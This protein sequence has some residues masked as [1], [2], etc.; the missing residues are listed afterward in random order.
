MC[1]K[2]ERKL[3]AINIPKGTQDTYQRFD[4]ELLGIYTMHW[5]KLVDKC[6]LS[7]IFLVYLRDINCSCSWVEPQNS[8]LE[9]IICTKARELDR[10]V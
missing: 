3:Y 2:A 7:N 1:M 5:T 6:S 10:A 4:E 9:W 8:S